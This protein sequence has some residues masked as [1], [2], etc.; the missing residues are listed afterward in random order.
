MVEGLPLPTIHPV[1]SFA[2]RRLLERIT[3]SVLPARDL[4]DN[5]GQQSILRTA[6]PFNQAKW[7]KSDWFAAFQQRYT[8][9]R[10]PN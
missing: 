5:N 10:Q 4:R 3:G 2:V 9:H 1:R 6:S 7:F 8:C